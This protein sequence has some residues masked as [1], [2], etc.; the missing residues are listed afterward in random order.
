[1]FCKHLNHLKMFLIFTGTLPKY[2]AA[3]HA[4]IIVA[5]L[6][7]LLLY[8][9]QEYASLIGE[10]PKSILNHPVPADVSLL[11]NLLLVGRV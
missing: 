6:L 4:I 8:A 11:I 5:L 7:W 9:G 1:M 2:R 3:E 10:N